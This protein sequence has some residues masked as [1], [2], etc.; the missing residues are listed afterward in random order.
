MRRI[1]FAA[2]LGAIILAVAIGSAWANP[3]SGPHRL[4]EQACANAQEKSPVVEFKG[5]SGCELKVEV[6]SH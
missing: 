6:P 1:V 2:V 5:M 3:T 4:P